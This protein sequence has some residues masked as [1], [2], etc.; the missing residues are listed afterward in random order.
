MTPRVLAVPY[1]RGFPTGCVGMENKWRI[2]RRHILSD[3]Q[4][5]RRA[6]MGFSKSRTQYPHW[7]HAKYNNGIR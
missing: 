3:K 7:I 2:K 6:F 1:N 5:F 4:R